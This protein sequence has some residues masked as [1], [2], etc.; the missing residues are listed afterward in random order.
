MHFDD[1][2]ALR[3]Q[4]ADHHHGLVRIVC[5]FLNLKLRDE[6]KDRILNLDIVDHVPVGLRNPSAI[7]LS[8]AGQL[9][10]SSLKTISSAA[11]STLAARSSPMRHGCLAKSSSFMSF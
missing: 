6:I 8:D 9:Q 11:M 4:F 7:S 5:D 3:H 1:G 10:R 2:Y